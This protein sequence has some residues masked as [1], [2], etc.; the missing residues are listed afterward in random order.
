MKNNS[1]VKKQ[2]NMICN[3]QRKLRMYVSDVEKKDFNTDEHVKH[4]IRTE[5]KS[6]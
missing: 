4:Y 2:R 1:H 5:E 3:Q 6:Q